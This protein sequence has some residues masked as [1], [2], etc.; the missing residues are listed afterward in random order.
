MRIALFFLAMFSINFVLEGQF[1][2]SET[3]IV[4][5][6][7]TSCTTIDMGQVDYETILGSCVSEASNHNAWLAFT[8]EGPDINIESS[9]DGGSNVLLTIVRFTGQD[10]D[11]VKFEEIVC[12][13][14]ELD[15]TDILIVGELYHVIVNVDNNAGGIV[16]VCITNEDITPPPPNDLPCPAIVMT[17]DSSCVVGTTTYAEPGNDATHCAPELQNE[18]WFKFTTGDGLVFGAQIFLHNISITGDFRVKLLEFGFQDCNGESLLKQQYC[19]NEF[20]LVIEYVSLEPNH[21]YYVSVATDEVSQG[22][23]ELCIKQMIADSNTDPCQATVLVPNQECINFDTYYSVFEY[24]L[25]FCDFSNQKL[26]YQ[27]YTGDDLDDISLTLSKVEDDENVFVGLGYFQGN[28]CGNTFIWSD[29]Y[30]GNVEDAS[31]IYDD[32]LPNQVYHVVIG[33]NYGFTGEFDLCVEGDYNSPYTNGSPCTAYQ[34]DDFTGCVSGSSEYGQLIT[35]DTL[36]FAVS[37]ILQNWYKIPLERYNHSIDLSYSAINSIPLHRIQVGYFE[38]GC[39]DTLIVQNEF[40]GFQQASNLSASFPDSID[41]AYVSVSLPESDDY[42]FSLCVNPLDLEQLCFEGDF[43]ETAVEQGEVSLDSLLCWEACTFGATRENSDDHFTSRY[44]TSWYRFTTG[45]QVEM[46]KLSLEQSTF[47]SFYIGLK[48][49]S[50]CDVDSFEVFR[51]IQITDQSE[52]YL[53][54]SG[55][56]QYLMAICAVTLQGATVDLCIEGLPA[57]RCPVEDRLKIV[58]TSMGSP[59]SGPF[60]EGEQVSF[61]YTIES[62]DVISEASCQWLQGIVPTF[63]LSWDQTSFDSF[64]MPTNSSEIIPVNNQAAWG[65]RNDVHS[66]MDSDYRRRFFNSQGLQL[67]HRE[68]ADCGGSPLKEGDLL[69]AGWYSWNFSQGGMHPDSTYGDGVFCN[70]NNGPWTVCF[71]LQVGELSNDVDLSVDMHTFSDGEIGLGGIPDTSC[72]AD[73]PLASNFYLNCDQT[74]LDSLIEISTCSGN[75]ITVNLPENQFFYWFYIDNPRVLGETTGS[76]TNLSM[77]L[78]TD[79]ETI[80]TVRYFAKAYNSNGC[81][82]ANYEIVVDVYPSLDIPRPDV[83]TICQLDSASM[84]DVLPLEDYIIGDF[85]VDWDSPILEDLPTAFWSG[86]SDTI[87]PYQVV[88]AA[89]C[90]FQDTISIHVEDVIVDGSVFPYT[91]CRDDQL[92]LNDVL[93]LDSLIEDP[94]TVDWDFGDLEDIPNADTSFMASTNIPFVLTG[95]NGCQYADTLGIIVPFVDVT[96]LGKNRYCSTD[97][98]SI[99][100]GYNFD[101]PHE[102][103]WIYPNGDTLNSAGI[104]RPAKL[105]NDGINYLEFHLFTEEGCPFYEYDTIEIFRLPEFS[106]NQD[107]FGLGVCSYDSL[108]LGIELST[109]IYEPLWFTPED[110]LVANSFYISTPGSYTVLSGFQDQTLDCTNSET[111]ELIHYPEVET[112]LSY[113]EIVCEGDSTV[114]SFSNPNNIFVWSTGNFSSEELLP[115]GDYQITVS[116]PNGCK[117]FFEVT[118][119]SQ[120][121]PNPSFSLLNE[122]CEGDSTWITTAE[123]DAYNYVWTDFSDST[124]FLSF[125]GEESVIVTDDLGCVDSFSFQIDVIEVPEVNFSYNAIQDTLF[126]F[127]NSTDIGDCE[128]MINDDLLGIAGDTMLILPEGDYVVSL[129]CNNQGCSDFQLEEINIT[130]VVV[131]GT[132]EF[133]DTQWHLYP[134][135]NSGRFD[136]K[137]EDEIYVDKVEVVDLQGVV[138]F[139]KYFDSIQERFKVDAQLTSG[140]YFLRVQS[141]NGITVQA[142]VVH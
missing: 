85:Y 25:P 26:W 24:D 45:E 122:I 55:D 36:C 73:L 140:A 47:P 65:W 118:V 58:N 128:W 89:G 90:F 30:C 115:A 49:A 54:L 86:G 57:D 12:G 104:A 91:V 38:N 33:T 79:E 87:I 43:C 80:S 44:P 132:N 2:C 116:N 17:T 69:P 107:T 18:V 15:Q 51:Y 124:A 83:Y 23:F 3:L 63:G 137:F 108:L 138:K 52:L 125:G 72:M 121:L 22:D 113:D 71:D 41:F 103:F 16:E 53:D 106:F 84:L 131:S 135:P 94:F 112:D 78:A 127:D 46:I 28:F 126:L 100:A 37:P 32:L 105:F 68:Q 29:T 34:I 6:D 88:S 141:S 74:P 8:A 21:E 31:L 114:I 60:Q 59:F 129:S 42:Y 11:P 20:G 48:K 66:K 70:E 75:S 13:T 101:L 97:T 67:C 95:E 136:V 40:C 35:D 76:G 61:C 133:R 111:F 27:F 56:T 99:S 4:D 92:F 14:N 19:G 39:L 7:P 120:A 109:S 82:L 142:F 139:V 93:N 9:H 81:H 1:S 117:D 119:N 96:V 102:R 98:V 50:D 77:T 62:F 110:T 64:G 10:C 5:G 134:N 123:D 130:I